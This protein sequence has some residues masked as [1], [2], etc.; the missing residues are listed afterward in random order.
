MEKEC[1]V[2]ISALGMVML[3]CGQRMIREIK[4]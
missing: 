2:P 1:I 3:E 4:G